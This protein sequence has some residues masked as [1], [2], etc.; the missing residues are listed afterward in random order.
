MPNTVKQ[1][2]SAVLAELGVL[3]DKLDDAAVDKLVG[4]LLESEVIFTAGAGRSGQLLRC[5][6]MRL[7]HFGKRVYVVGEMV[8]PAIRKGDLLLMVSGSGETGSL[9]SMANKAKSI[10]AKIAL[11]SANPDSTISRLADVYVR[12]FAP[13]PKASFKDY[14]ESM[15]PMGN[16]FEQGSFLFLDAVVMEMMARTGKTSETMFE[17]HA[18]L[19]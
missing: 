11:V 12:I 19:E 17:L 15:Q 2:L 8:T 1:N 14:V 18:N 3:F 7:M 16:M 13:S 6:A 10:G 5:A 9:V 4:I